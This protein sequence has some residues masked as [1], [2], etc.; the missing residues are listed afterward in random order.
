MPIPVRE[1]I[2][3]IDPSYCIEVTDDGSRT[4]LRDGNR[5]HSGCGAIAECDWVYL[6]GVGMNDETYEDWPRSILEV[7]FGTGMAMLRTI[8]RALSAGQPIE[9]V[10][11]ENSPISAQ[12]LEELKLDRDL[13][14][15]E[16]V[17][18]FLERWDHCLRSTTLTPELSLAWDAQTKVSVIFT[19]AV[20]WLTNQK[21]GSE[22]KFD[23]VYFDPFDPV[24]NPELW[25]TEV[26][27]GLWRR[28]NLGG[29]LV[30]YCVQGEVRRSLQ[31]AGFETHRVPGPPF[32]KRQVLIAT[33]LAA[34]DP[35]P[36]DDQNSSG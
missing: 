31:R 2:S 30:T 22:R 20:A 10:A 29:R 19:D 12:I 13:Q 4:L 16:L 11:L 32:G 26:L 23:A 28:I 34:E 33:K 5:F 35:V 24:I 15:P 1:Q 17:P 18:W 27:Q 9:Y 3:T 25:Q 8:D 36:S 7:G 6:R 21:P 14:R